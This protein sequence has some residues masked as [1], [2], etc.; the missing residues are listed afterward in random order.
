MALY[1]VVARGL[2]QRRG[3]RRTPPP[4]V[5]ATGLERDAVVVA[6]GVVERCRAVDGSGGYGWLVVRW[7]GVGEAFRGGLLVVVARVSDSQQR[8]DDEYEKRYGT[9][10]G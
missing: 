1:G 4:A 6:H 3:A 10:G 8:D 5:L 9:T 2:P 7:V